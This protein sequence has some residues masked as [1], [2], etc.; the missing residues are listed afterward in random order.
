MSRRRTFEERRAWREARF[1][2]RHPRP[3]WWPED[4]S[5]PPR[6]PMTQRPLARRALPFVLFITFMLLGAAALLTRFVQVVYLDRPLEPHPG[7]PGFLLGGLGML[8]FVG[9][10]LRRGAREIFTPLDDIIQASQRA[11]DGDTSVRVRESGGPELRALASTFNRMMAQL[12]AQSDERQDMLADVTHELRTPLTVIQ[13]TIEG[14]QDGI[15]PA[16]EAHFADLLAETDRLSHLID[17]LRT[18][19]LSERGALPMQRES[20]DL[21]QLASEAL[22]SFQLQAAEK[23]IR[24]EFDAAGDLPNIDVDPLR[25]RQVLDNLIANALRA[26]GRDD[27]ITLSLKREEDALQLSIADTGAGIAAKDVPHVFERFYKS[28]SSSGSGLGLA[29]ARDL[30]RAHGGTI[31][32]D[33]R[34][35]EQTIFTIQLPLA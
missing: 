5:W 18:L 27:A 26:C 35:G 4:E 11:A 7:G 21:I 13:G 8:L 28:E 22:A 33:S 2:A 17:D 23:D 15:Y 16:D 1:A 12:Q 10:M 31:S 32:V 29:I 9:F 20:T 25:L 30:V 24:L 14:M 34:Q 3:D 6:A 19:S